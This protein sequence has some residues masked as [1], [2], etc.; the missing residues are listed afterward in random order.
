MSQGREFLNKVAIPALASKMGD[1]D[2]V[3]IVGVNRN[4]NYKE[5]FPKVLEID[6]NPAT[7]PDIVDDICHSQLQSE[8]A[9]AV[10][11]IGVYEFLENPTLAIKE[12]HRI[13]KPNGHLLAALPGR[14]HWRAPGDTNARISLELVPNYLEGFKIHQMSCF[15]AENNELESCV[16]FAEKV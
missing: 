6:I 1:E 8:V 10:L 9:K 14:G 2:M 5:M 3:V 15:Y 7:N 16:I 11:F 13:L 12:V 4:Y